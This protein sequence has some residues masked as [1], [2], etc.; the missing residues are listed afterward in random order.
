MAAVSTGRQSGQQSES[1]WVWWQ[2]NFVDWGNGEVVPGNKIRA[3]DVS[4]KALEPQAQYYSL[5]HIKVR[6]LE[7]FHMHVCALGP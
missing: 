5:A 4:L 7:V 1:Q 3:I 6:P 2:V